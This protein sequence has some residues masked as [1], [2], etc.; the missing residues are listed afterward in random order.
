[1][2]P[3]QILKIS[4]IIRLITS[5]TSEEDLREHTTEEGNREIINSNNKLAK[6]QLPQHNSPIVAANK[7]S[8]RCNSSQLQSA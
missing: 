5:K 8:H 4:S 6:M 3:Q 2:L 1:M 7:Y